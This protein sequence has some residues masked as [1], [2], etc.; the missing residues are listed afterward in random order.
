[1]NVTDYF[2]AVLVVKIGFYIIL[3]KLF[4][5]NDVVK[6]QFI[7]AVFVLSDKGFPSDVKPENVVI[8]IRFG[9]NFHADD[10]V[11]AKNN[12]FRAGYPF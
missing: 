4:V 7:V 5:V 9:G 8:K 3:H 1:M 10:P 6:T 11:G 12:D 2:Y